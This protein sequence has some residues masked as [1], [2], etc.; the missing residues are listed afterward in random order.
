MAAAAP[1]P[2]FGNSGKDAAV[3]ELGRKREI[4]I[5]INKKRGYKIRRFVWRKGEVKK[6][7]GYKIRR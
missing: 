7:K 6:K 4:K 2:A 1:V 5:K 3:G